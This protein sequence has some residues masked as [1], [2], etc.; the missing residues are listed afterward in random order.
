MNYFSNSSDKVSISISSLPLPPVIAANKQI[1]CLGNKAIITSNLA[2]VN[3]WYRNGIQLVSDSG[4]S[5]K[6]TEPGVYKLINKTVN[7]CFTAASNEIVLIFNDVPAKPTV[8][9]DGPLIFCEGDY[10][11]LKTTIPAWSTVQWY[12]DG[13]LMDG[14][15]KDTLRIS[16]GGKYTARFT[17]A[18]GCSSP[19]SDCS[20]TEVKCETDIY[21]PDIFTSNDDKINDVIKP[22]IPGIRKFVWFKVYNRWGNLVFY[23]TDP[24]KGWDGKYK[25]AIQPAETN[26]WIVEGFDSSG[27]KINKSG[28][29]S[30]MR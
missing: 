29:L 17:N 27:K 24:T 16:V 3:L 10:R 20:C 15:T 4:K 22:S 30:L 1:Y 18:S 5:I 21:T 12:K 26:M 8:I 25:G 6:A 2:S 11:I 13:V 14:K 9:I 23:I 19:F 28:M 7:G